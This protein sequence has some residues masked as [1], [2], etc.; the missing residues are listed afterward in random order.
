MRGGFS[1][2]E[3]VLALAVM[4]LAVSVL[5][6]LLPHGLE[7]ARKAGVAAGDARITSDI[8]AEL[9]QVKWTDLPQYDNDLFYFDDQG[10]RR[11]RGDSSASYVARVQLPANSSLP[12]SRV[13]MS[14][15]LRRVVIQV[16]ASPNPTF[17]FDA[18]GASYSTYVSLISRNNE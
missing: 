7:M 17:N 9:S 5:L 4:G 13:N 1:L 2:V 10:V 12:G 6:G 8:L 11:N 16:A 15:N 3:T 18:P 14:E